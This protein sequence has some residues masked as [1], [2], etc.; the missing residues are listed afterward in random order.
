MALS[1]ARRGLVVVGHMGTLRGSS[2]W[3]AFLEHVDQ[4]G[5]RVRLEHLRLNI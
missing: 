2:T 1:R 3:G 5:C 4:Q